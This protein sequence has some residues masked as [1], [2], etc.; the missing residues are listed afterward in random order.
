MAAGSALR[1]AFQGRPAEGE[2]LPWNDLVGLSH[3]LTM[4]GGAGPTY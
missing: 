2:I 3:P 1:K 4:D